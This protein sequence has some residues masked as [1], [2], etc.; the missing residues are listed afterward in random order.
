M[1]T[2]SFVLLTSNEVICVGITS[3]KVNKLIKEKQKVQDKAKAMREK[4][5][6]D[7]K[8]KS[9]ENKVPKK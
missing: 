9:G 2:A 8:K 5:K 3:H 7:K 4:K 6:S 1:I